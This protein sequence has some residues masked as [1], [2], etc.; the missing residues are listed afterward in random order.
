M[1]V[2]TEKGSFLA[3]REWELRTVREKQFERGVVE[4]VMGRRT[5][6]WRAYEE[7][8]EEKTEGWLT[9]VGWESKNQDTA[10]RLLHRVKFAG[11]LPDEKIRK[12]CDFAAEAFDWLKI[13]DPIKPLGRTMGAIFS[14]DCSGMSSPGGKIFLP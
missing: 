10:G 3:R 1:G 9:N 12:G 7:I 13:M 14:S 2:E 5:G 6:T 11:G 4:K 8:S